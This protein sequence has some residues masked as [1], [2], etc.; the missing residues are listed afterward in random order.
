MSEGL[1]PQPLSQA[2]Y[3]PGAALAVDKRMGYTYALTYELQL[4]CG[5]G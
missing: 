2:P 4:A 5:S 1:A 3:Q